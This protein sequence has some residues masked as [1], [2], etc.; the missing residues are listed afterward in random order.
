MEVN[1][2][3][4]NPVLPIPSNTA[5]ETQ[6]LWSRKVTKKLKKKKQ[7]H[8]FHKASAVSV[9]GILFKFSHHLY[10]I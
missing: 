6:L 1:G 3:D 8:N 4:T 10:H 9:N 5:S 2:F 7:K